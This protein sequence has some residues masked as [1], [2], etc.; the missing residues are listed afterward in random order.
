MSK[1]LDLGPDEL[2]TTTRAVRKRLDF[3]RELPLELVRECV[4]I[5]I[6]APTGSNAQGWHFVVVSDAA[7]RAAIA[8]IYRKNW[9]MYENMPFSAHKVHEGDASM[10]AVQDRVVSS[11]QYLA[12]NLHRVPVFL[13]PCV[14]GRVDAV[15]PPMGNLAQASSFGSIL[16]AAWSFM[17]AARARGLGTCFTTLH[18]WSEVEC[19]EILGIPHASITQCGLIPVAWYTGDTFRPAPRKPLDPIFH[20]DTW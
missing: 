13:I 20:V 8:E 16:P 12:E 2:L 1:T 19:A 6:Q 17:L 14:E 4:E 7:K 9:A 15:P 3:D 11:A 5:A 18:L 10:T